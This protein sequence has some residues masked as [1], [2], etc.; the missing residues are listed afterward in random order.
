[1][2]QSWFFDDTL[3]YQ[4]SKQAVAKVAKSFITPIFLTTGAYVVATKT[5]VIGELRQYA[6]K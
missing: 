2:T 4:Y 1:M 3:Y 6:G 5:N